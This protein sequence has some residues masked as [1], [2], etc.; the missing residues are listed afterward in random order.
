[1]ISRENFN[2]ID[3]M[4]PTN[5][6]LITGAAGFIGFHLAQRLLERGDQVCGLDNMNDYYDVNL[7]S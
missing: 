2:P 3:T 1:M 4:Q 5:K 7:A 6:T